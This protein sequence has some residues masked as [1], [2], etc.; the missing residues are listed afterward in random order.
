MLVYPGEHKVHD[1]SVS[2]TLVKTVKLVEADSDDMTSDG[3]NN[4]H[5]CP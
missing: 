3:L 5:A 4:T 2:N 1:Q